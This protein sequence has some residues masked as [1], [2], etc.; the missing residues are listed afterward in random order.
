MLTYLDPALHC[1]PVLVFLAVVRPFKF[2]IWPKRKT[3]IT[4]RALELNFQKR[5]L[6]KNFNSLELI[7][8]ERKR[9][10]TVMFSLG[11]LRSFLVAR[12]ILSSPLRM[13]GL[14]WRNPLVSRAN[15]TTNLIQA[16]RNYKVR[17][18]VKKMCASCYVARRKGRVY[19]LC[20]SNPKHKQRQG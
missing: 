10:L 18:S 12:S 2:Q 5:N 15:N 16:E 3:S 11:R 13:V 4:R 1:A 6:E 7:D 8:R 14:L 19:V 17:T 20:K 9:S